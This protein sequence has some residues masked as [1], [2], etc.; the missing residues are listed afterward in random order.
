MKGIFPVNLSRSECFTLQKAV[1]KKVLYSNIFE[2]RSLGSKQTYV[3]FW[4]SY[5]Q[6]SVQQTVINI[7]D[8]GIN[9]K[10]VSPGCEY[11]GENYPCFVTGRRGV[12]SPANS[13]LLSSA[14]YSYYSSS[15]Q[16]LYY[17]YPVFCLL[18]ADADIYI[19]LSTG[20]G[21]SGVLYRSR[22]V[23]KNTI[24]MII[25]RA[26]WDWCKLYGIVLC[27]V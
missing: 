10:S 4:S 27:V 5:P 19:D 7:F 16:M 14:L 22:A 20:G 13:L 18:S 3:F 8:N 2:V 25:S 6:S 26:H 11:L 23:V 15:N 24:I 9:T 1:D 21:D 17:W 12:R